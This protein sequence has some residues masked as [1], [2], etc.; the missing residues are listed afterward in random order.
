MKGELIINNVR[1]ELGYGMLNDLSY[2]LD[3]SKMSRGIFH[4]LAKS[5]CCETRSYIASRNNLYPKTV[6]ILLPDQQINVMRAMVENDNF[7][8]QMNKTDV[9]RFIHT[10]DPEILTGI[11]NAMSDLTEIYDVC[12]RDWL[13]EKFY[14]HPDPAVRYE[15]ANNDET[16]EFFLKKLRED[17]D[18]AVV[19]AAQDTLDNIE[20]PFDDDD[21]DDEF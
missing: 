6:T 9:E 10:G 17:S 13:C 21:D 14:Q 20:D 4:E 16:P 5:P 2:S 11:V 7:I 8:S 19:R 18:V 3:D 12:E 1:L 15:L